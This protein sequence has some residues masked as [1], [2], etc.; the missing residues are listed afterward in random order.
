MPTAASAMAALI[1]IAVATARKASD[2]SCSTESITCSSGS[3]RETPIAELP[4][5]PVWIPELL[6]AFSIAAS[7]P[8]VR[9]KCTW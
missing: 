2:K 9:M 7:I 8:R 5:E 3:Q 1:P 6:A 4:R